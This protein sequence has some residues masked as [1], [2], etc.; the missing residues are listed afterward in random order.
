MPAALS[1]LVQTPVVSISKSN[2]TFFSS[3]LLTFRSRPRRFKL[4]W[5]FNYIHLRYQFENPASWRSQVTKHTT[6]WMSFKK[7]GELK[8]NRQ[9]LSLETDVKLANTA[10]QHVERSQSQL[11]Q[12]RLSSRDSITIIIC[13][14]TLK[15]Q[16]FPNL[17]SQ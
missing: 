3:W 10:L 5:H 15:S 9:L 16:Y 11:K 17:L 1:L 2:I 14:V 6:S 8:W 13:I 7:C 4:V 12:Y